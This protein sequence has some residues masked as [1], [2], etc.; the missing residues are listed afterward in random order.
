AWRA[1]EAKAGRIYECVTQTIGGYPFRF[2]LNCDNAS[3]LFATNQPPV[4]LKAK[5]ILVAAQIYQP[6]LLISEFHGPLTV[7]TPGQPPR[8]IMNWKLFQSSVHGTPSRPERV[9]LVFD[10][11]VLD[12]ID[13]GVTHTLLR[14]EHIELHGRIAE[15][16]I[17]DHPAIEVALRLSQGLAPNF[18][19]AAVQPVDATIDTVLRGLD[20]FSPKPWHERFRQMQANGGSIEV[21]QA[22]IQQGETTAV[23]SGSVAI[24]ANG[25]LQGQLR[26][27]IAGLE[28]F[29]KTVG[30]EQMVQNSAAVDKL[31]G[32]LDRLAPGLGSVAR[33]Q[34]GANISAG[35]NMIGEPATLDGKKAVTLPL[36]FD[37]GRMFLGP[38]P[39]G[40]A[41]ALF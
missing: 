22:R 9:S 4:E 35:I 17:N 36:R 13:N 38:I 28:A 5:G 33:Q 21:T 24:N 12:G 34:V 27:T 39:L 7:A 32:A 3:A 31:A 19:P 23:G 6:N 26:M 37:D 30:A 16:A 20:D 40:E 8:L 11:P 41:P 1:R 15:G 10:K 2:E 14:A 25:R 18:R 29:L